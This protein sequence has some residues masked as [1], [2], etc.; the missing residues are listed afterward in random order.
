[1]IDDKDYLELFNNKIEMAKYLNSIKS[2][3]I[4][5]A[6]KLFIKRK[7][8]IEKNSFFANIQLKIINK[9]INK[10]KK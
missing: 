8:I 2:E 9:K 4:E 6:Q 5:L 7:N 3:K 10:L 1:M